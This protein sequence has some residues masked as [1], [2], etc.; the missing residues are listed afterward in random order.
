MI[1]SFG[2]AFQ[3]LG[4]TV[5]LVAADDYQPE[6]VEQYD[7]NIIFMQTGL[8]KLFH[9]S[10]FPFLPHLPS[11]L[12]KEGKQFDL[13]ISSEVFTTASLFSVLFCNKNTLIWQELNVHNRMFHQIPSKLWYNI[14]GK[15]FFRNTLIIPRSESAGNF[16]S[17][18]C[19]NVSPIP[20]D[21]GVNLK[22]YIFSDKKENQFI[23]AAQLIK[24][25]NVDYIIHQFAGFV[26]THPHKNYQ[27]AIAG[28]GTEE[29]NLKK[30]VQKL[31]LENSV[32]FLGFLNHRELNEQ[33]A[34]SIAFLIATKKDL[35]MVSIPESIVSGT[36]ILSNTVPALSLYIIKNRLGICK[37]NWGINE[38]ESM[39][40]NQEEFVRNCISKRTDLSSEYAAL[41]MIGL[42]QNNLSL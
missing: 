8:K 32:H 31:S 2:L 26:E 37:D 6:T 30:L 39:I 16:I 9:P 22:K 36:P 19:N 27:L 35:N 1:Y 25:K 17:R 15:L 23:V 4:H 3:S 10:I 7:F 40:T 42:F 41:K 28:R 33:I 29:E 18:F 13:I 12:R 24:R 14:I 5:T 21:H 34:R 38:L 11:F 20:V